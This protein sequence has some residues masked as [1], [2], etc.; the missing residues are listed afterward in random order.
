MASRLAWPARLRPWRRWIVI[1][2]LLL[3]VRV[4]L[5]FAL[6]PLL[7]AQ[8]SKA[9]AARVE[10]G[11][12]DLDLYRCGIALR[13]VAIHAAAGPRSGADEQPLIA[14]QRLAVAVRWLPLFSKEVLLREL[15]L[16]SPRVAVDRNEDGR[17]NLLA[18]VPARGAPPAA[19]PAGTGWAFGVDRLSLRDGGLR[20][21]D[22]KVK[23]SEPLLLT[24]QDLQLTEIAVRSGIY[25][26]PAQMRLVVN[27][28]GGSVELRAR[29]TQRADGQALAA[30][31]EVRNLPLYRVPYYVQ[32]VGWRTLDG[33]LDTQLT[34]SFD[35]RGQHQA[36]GS[37]GLRDVAI[38]VPNFDEPALTYRRLTVQLDA[39][40]LSARRLHVAAF[41]LD[42]ATMFVDRP[43][44]DRVP[45]LAAVLH[46]G[47]TAAPAG[48]PAAAAAPRLP[49]QPWHWSLSALR[50]T[51]SHV[52][53]LGAQAPLDVGF[54]VTASDIADDAERPGQVRTVF[55]VGKGSVTVDGGVRLAGLGFAGTVSIAAFPLAEVLAAAAVLPADLLQ[56]VELESELTV[57][58]GLTT[59][60]ADAG[61]LAAGDL[62][63]RGR[64]GLSDLKVTG[65]DARIFALGTR[66]VELGIKD[67][68]VPGI[69]PGGEA[70]A[71]PRPLRVALG[72]VRIA[73]LN[74]RVTRTAEGIA[75][76]ALSAA[77]GSGGTRAPAPAGLPAAPEPAKEA[78]P[79]QSV[80]VTVEHVRLTEGNVVVLDRTVRPFFEGKFSPLTI[81]VRG[82][83]WPPFAARDIRLT[84]TTTDQGK[85]KV[86]GSLDPRKG[87]IE[88]NV[89][90]LALA[91][92]NP[93]VTSLAGYSIGGG[94]ASVVTRVVFA[95]DRY[96]ASNALTLHTLDVRGAGGESLF[97]ESFGIPLSTAL[98]LMRDINGDIALDIP[99]R[100][101][102]AGVKVGVAALIR[103]ALQRA[104]LGALT[105]PLKLVGA[106]FGGGKV[107]SVTPTSIAFRVGRAEFAPGGADQ[108][109][110]LAALL[111]SRPGIAV[112]LATAPTAADVRW[113]REQALRAEWAQ[114]GFFGK[115]Q[116]LTQ[117]G[118]RK[119]IGLAIEA[120][121]RDEEGKL[122]A[123]DAA[124]LDRW[125]DER[126]PIAD[127]RLQAL[128]E[129][130][131]V[132]VE[133]ILSDQ[134]GI[135]A[136]RVKRRE[137]APE[138]AGDTPAVQLELGALASP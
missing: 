98:A 86:A 38:R 4:A 89:D 116:G 138:P 132:A 72:D 119:T 99:V 73:G 101:D 65:T 66:S 83:S 13:N 24:L 5:P 52:R 12:V 111:S 96:D 67:L 48:E 78:A 50:V 2:G 33:W 41:E 18:L 115:V 34:Y 134:H 81:D 23:G 46:R 128:A 137:M 31:I 45:L 30:D 62:R 25:E 71:A 19:A 84:A 60:A 92:F 113:L 82:V 107:Q 122:E 136:N 133:Q 129:A 110:Q 93:Y 43:G 95:Q 80:E 131:L 117:R 70:G 36:R 124:T 21:R 114:E 90:K 14:W 69:L 17:I 1:G 79:A 125:L 51:D 56:A 44:G 103:Q 58:A 85:I 35:S 15:V 88:L 75:L 123:D 104:I 10:I 47:A 97:Q 49:P 118:A 16:E 100:M 68:V 102:Q 37:I 55:T 42:G 40:D 91:P 6:R 109:E 7:A 11:A 57:E 74:V 27:V 59:E 112:T 105:S 94:R 121:A 54:E 26:A 29:L 64:V 63:V 130:R 127:A 126:P 32:E 20:F 28:E 87:W 108:V 39:L 53:V 135:E 77:P 61:G 106:V 3:A 76:P 9:L 22:F 8:A 120:R